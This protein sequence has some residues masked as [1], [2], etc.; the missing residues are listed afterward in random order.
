VG[1]TI[2]EDVGTGAG[3]SVGIPPT[4]ADGA[5]VPGV[6]VGERVPNS[7]PFFALNLAFDLDFPFFLLLLLAFFDFL[8]VGIAVAVG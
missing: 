4:G 8:P 1:D 2:G 7:L 6:G 3:A 5:S